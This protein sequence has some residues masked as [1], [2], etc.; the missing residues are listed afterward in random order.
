M[1]LPKLS[2]SAAGAALDFTPLMS[3]K[4]ADYWFCAKQ[5]RITAALLDNILTHDHRALV[6]DYRSKHTSRSALFLQLYQDLLRLRQLETLANCAYVRAQALFVTVL[7]EAAFGH[8]GGAT[9]TAGKRRH[10]K[11]VWYKHNA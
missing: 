6:R 9:M 2:F 3:R 7:E 8:D 5:A 11:V 4:E 10:K 1:K